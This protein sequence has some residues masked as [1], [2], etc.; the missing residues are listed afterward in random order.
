LSALICERLNID[1]PKIRNFQFSIMSSNE[2]YTGVMEP[3]SE[4]LSIAHNMDTL[5]LATFYDN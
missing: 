4:L 1:Y 2:Y 5:D 3:Y